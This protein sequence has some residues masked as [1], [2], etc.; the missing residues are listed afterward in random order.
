M[1]SIFYFTRFRGKNKF[2]LFAKEEKLFCYKSNMKWVTALIALSLLFLLS[3]VTH[4]AKLEGKVFPSSEKH[5]S[6][7]SSSFRALKFWI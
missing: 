5:F 4:A 3:D 1:M 6:T 2:A 7:F